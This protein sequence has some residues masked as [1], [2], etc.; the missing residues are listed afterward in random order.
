[1]NKKIVSVILILA[2]IYT[3]FELLNIQKQSKNNVNSE[4]IKTNIV[5][6]ASTTI[7]ATSTDSEGNIISNEPNPNFGGDGQE[8]PVTGPMVFT[9]A[10]IASHNNAKSCYTA[11]RGTV[12]DLTN[13]ISAH[14]G[15]AGNILKICGKDG[16]NSFVRKHG[17][18]PEP[19]QELAGHE[20]GILK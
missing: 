19:E 9:L 3:G 6:T 1:M 8:D 20:I 17:G 15:G 5:D 7:P 18:R 4:Y 12:Y 2:V 11:V 10:D 14:R 16:T 13:F